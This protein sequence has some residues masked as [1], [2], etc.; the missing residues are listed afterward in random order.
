MN[1]FLGGFC[2]RRAEVDIYTNENT[3]ETVTA[4]I[5]GSDHAGLA[6][7]VTGET[8]TRYIP[9]TEIKQVRLT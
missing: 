1:T 6:I 9:W 3:I 5:E 4:R 8:Q 7:R 2:S